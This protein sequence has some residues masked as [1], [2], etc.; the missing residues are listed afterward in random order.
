MEFWGD[1]RQDVLIV[2]GKCHLGGMV[3]GHKEFHD[4]DGI[5]TSRV[6]TMSREKRRS[7]RKASCD[8]IFVVTGSGSEYYIYGD[9]INPYMDNLVNDM[10]QYGKLSNESGSYIKENDLGLF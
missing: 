5:L 7:R 9:D 6:M 4:G 2:E 3:Y 10:F 8:L 1:Q